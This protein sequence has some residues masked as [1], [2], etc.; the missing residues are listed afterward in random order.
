MEPKIKTLVALIDEIFIKYG[1]NIAFQVRNKESFDTITYTQFVNHVKALAASI[2]ELGY[3]NAHIGIIGEN[4]YEWV[5]CYMAI[6]Y[7]GNVVVPIDKDLTSEEISS[8]ISMSDTEA[9][10][11][12]TA[13]DESVDPIM[14]KLENVKFIKIAK[15]AS[16]NSIY[17][18]I[19][20]GESLQPYKGIYPDENAMCSIVFTSG[21]TGFSK[22]VMLSHK[23]MLSDCYA[24]VP[25]A[26]FTGTTLSMLP[27]HH[28]YEFTLGTLFTFLQGTSISINNSIKYLAQNLQIF[29]PTDLLVV[30]LIVETLYNKIWQNIRNT[31]KEK[32][33][34]TMLSVSRF[35][36]SI[37]IDIRKILFKKILAALGGNLKSMFCGGA[38]LDLEVA[39]G[40]YDFGVDLNIGYGI[41]ECSPLIHGNCTHIRSKYGSCGKSIICCETKIE[42]PNENGE[43]EILVRGENIMLGY[44]KNPEATAEVMQEGW[45]KTGDIGYKD[46]DEF[47]YITGRKK[48]VI[49]LKNGKN[50]YPEE[51]EA[52]IYKIEFV[53]EVIVSSTDTIGEELAISAEIF[54]DA[55]AVEQK[56][57]QSA[58]QK[59]KDSIET[60]NDTLAFYKRITDIKFRDIEFP[61]TTTKKI[62]RY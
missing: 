19:A 61:K 1:H 16:E 15:K 18:M 40:M 44:Y 53:K 24:C 20:K 8:I 25:I 54:I 35:L 62:K 11:Y 60:L 34:K 23:N 47:L 38:L 48:N 46:A 57:E 13:Y 17:G 12:S 51:L 4:S 10:F 39:Q 43:G 30:P 42:S 49:V 59:I 50:I 45:Y 9:L 22:G 5:V 52:Y 41:T 27:L 7:S 2:H 29:Q 31:G 3:N 36:M 55:E 37:G 56:G 6:V 28:T 14:D 21:T 32:T 33:V 26:K 58:E